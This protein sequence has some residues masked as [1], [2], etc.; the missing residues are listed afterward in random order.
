MCVCAF[1]G[2]K[3]V[4]GGDEKGGG[5]TA[6]VAGTL[7]EQGRNGKMFRGRFGLEPRAQKARRGA[8][9][10]KK[11]LSLSKGKTKKHFFHF[12]G[13]PFSRQLSLSFRP[14]HASHRPRSL[15]CCLATA[16]STL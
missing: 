5:G 8:N 6:A 14:P 9:E 1:G 3:K 16:E 7:G 12:I 10:K 11:T 15:R 4:K 13:H 2:K